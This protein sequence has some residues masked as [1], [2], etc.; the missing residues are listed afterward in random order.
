M[1]RGWF[2][3]NR[4]LREDENPFYSTFLKF[5]AV[6]QFSSSLSAGLYYNDN[7]LFVSFFD[8]YYDFF[9]FPEYDFM[10]RHLGLGGVYRLRRIALVGVEYHFK[11]T[12]QERGMFYNHRLTKESLNIGIE[13]LTRERLALRGGY[14]RKEIRE[15]PINEESKHGWRNVLTI[16]AGYELSSLKLSLDLAYRYTWGTIEI[17][18]YSSWPYAPAESERNILAISVKKFLL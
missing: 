8:P 18:E 3:Y 17:W 4:W 10:I 1:G 6:Y 15:N 11:D 5:R 12:A 14:I 13:I 7:D 2:S 16:G 9:R